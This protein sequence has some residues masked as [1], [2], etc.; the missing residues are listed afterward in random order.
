[1]TNLIE[2]IRTDYHILGDDR[3]EHDVKAVIVMHR[4]GRM[5]IKLTSVTSTGIVELFTNDDKIEELGS[6]IAPCP[7]KMIEIL[8]EHPNGLLVSEFAADQGGFFNEQYITAPL[9]KRRY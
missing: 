4:P 3:D 5:P 6:R 1:M 9:L 2:R 8:R 7:A